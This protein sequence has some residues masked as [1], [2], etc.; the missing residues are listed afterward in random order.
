MSGNIEMNQATTAVLESSRRRPLLTCAPLRTGRASWPRIR[1]K[2]GESPSCQ[3]A[4]TRSSLAE[5]L[6]LAIRNRR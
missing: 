6:P 3:G 4:G 2:H 5:N 1:L